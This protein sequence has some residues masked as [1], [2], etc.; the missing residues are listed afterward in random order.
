MVMKRWMRE[1]L[2]LVTVVLFLFVFWGMFVGDI[3]F[4]EEVPITKLGVAPWLGEIKNEKDL[5][6]KFKREKM[7]FVGYIQ[8]DL[9]QGANLDI[10]DK[11]AYEII[12]SMESVMKQDKVKEISIA[13]GTVFKSMGWK[14]KKGNVMRTKNPILKLGKPTKGFS[15]KVEFKDYEIEYLFLKDCGNLCLRNL[16]SEV[17]P[18]AEYVPQP[19]EE[20]RPPRVQTPPPSLPPAE[21]PPPPPEVE[22]YVYYPPPPP[23][24]YDY[25]PSVSYFPLPPPPFI[26]FGGGYG[27]RDYGYR[28]YGYRGYGGYRDYGYRHY[29][30]Y[31]DHRSPRVHSRPSAPRTRPSGVRTR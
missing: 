22:V 20:T 17:P 16:K 4:G 30:R 8:Y 18:K 19:R 21:L 28:D 27:Y 9:K 1:L 14:S 23:P 10:S 3:A 12:N 13:D 11:E 6:Q 31:R 7:D 24:V 26:F 5:L 25:Y 2:V 29:G 15:V